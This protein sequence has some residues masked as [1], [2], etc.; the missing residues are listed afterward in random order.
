MAFHAPKLAVTVLNAVIRG[1]VSVFGAIYI[2]VKLM[3]RQVE[4]PAYLF[5]KVRG[6]NEGESGVS[7]PSRR[8]RGVAGI[9]LGERPYK[10]T[11]DLV[12]SMV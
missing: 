9:A 5:T 4:N 3:L 10:G 11:G 6:T 8:Q 7:C 12:L 1:G 2:A